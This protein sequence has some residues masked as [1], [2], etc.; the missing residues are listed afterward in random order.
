MSAI[1]SLLLGLLQ[2]LTE[3]LPISS[4]GHLAL[5]K[6]LLGLGGEDLA[7]VVF[8]HFGTL[9]ATVTAFRR[10][11]GGMILSSGRFVVGRGVRGD[12]YLRL[13]GLILVGSIP[14]A[15]VGLLLEEGVEKAFSSTILVAFML[16]LTG[17]IL[18]LTRYVP[19]G[20]KAVGIKE[21]ILV[22]C[23]QALAILP[24]VS[25]SGATIGAALFQGVNK[26]RAVKFSFLLAL[27]AI[28]GATALKAV[29]L[30][31]LP[32]SSS[33]FIS[34]FLGTMAAYISGYAAIKV[35]LRVVRRGKLCYFAFYCWAVGLLG[36]LLS[37]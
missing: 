24:G 9:L 10:E 30:W 21:A 4:S 19:A 18:W 34:L 3:F 25:R 31:R 8:V 23:A 16:L 27:P 33:A 5:A 12:P 13:A 26:D 29:D 15:V 1:E 20:K 35:L 36:L 2:G 37:V 14:A 7:F 32:P 22:G 28:L 11:V 17:L 6:H